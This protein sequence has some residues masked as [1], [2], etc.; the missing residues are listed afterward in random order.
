[1][2]NINTKI[3]SRTE[4]LVAISDLE[5]INSI[6]KD[7][8]G[9]NT[10]FISNLAKKALF[11]VAQIYLAVPYF[12]IS[13]AN[14]TTGYNFKAI[15]DSSWKYETIWQGLKGLKNASSQ[16]GWFSREY[17]AADF[18]K[19]VGPNHGFLKEVKQLP[20]GSKKEVIVINGAFRRFANTMQFSANWDKS[21][22]MITRL[23]TF[24]NSFC[25]E[26]SDAE[27]KLRDAISEVEKA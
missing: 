9:K 12:I 24:R 20:D 19:A 18:M 16:M 14:W 21:M 5:R 2:A 7:L 10:N 26:S 8:D 4:C 15:K 1:M 27:K 23:T 11:T 22:E 3:L 13:F 6:K 25:H 17:D